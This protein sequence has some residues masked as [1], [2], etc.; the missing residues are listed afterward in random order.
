MKRKKKHNLLFP[1][2]MFKCTRC[3]RCCIEDAKRGRR[4]VLTVRDA[5][6]IL[7]ATGISL[8]EF[9]EEN[10]SEA[11][12][13]VIRLVNGRCF[14]LESDRKCRIYQARPLVCRFYPF[15]MQKIRGKY[16]FHADPACPGLGKGT[17]LDEEYFKRLVEQAERRLDV[18]SN[19]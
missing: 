18:A 1:R 14:F 2:T 13:Y 15:M 19:C 10:N 16:V 5:L 9:S 12:P 17:Y 4:I 11:Y 6:E 7:D 3:G 8:T